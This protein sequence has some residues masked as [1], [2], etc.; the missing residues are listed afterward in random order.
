MYLIKLGVEVSFQVDSVEEVIDKI[1]T[2]QFSRPR[3]DRVITVEHRTDMNNPVFIWFNSGGRLKHLYGSEY[4]LYV[5]SATGF[6]LQVSLDKH[7]GHGG[8]DYKKFIT[9]IEVRCSLKRLLFQEGK[10]ST[11]NYQAVTGENQVY[12]AEDP[13]T[14]ANYAAAYMKAAV[15]ENSALRISRTDEGHSVLYPARVDLL[16]RNSVNA[17]TLASGYPDRTLFKRKSRPSGRLSL[18]AAGNS[19]RDLKESVMNALIESK[20]FLPIS[21]SMS[22]WDDNK[23]VEIQ[24][25]MPSFTSSQPLHYRES[26]NQSEDPS[27]ASDVEKAKRFLKH[28]SGSFNGNPYF[29]EDGYPKMEIRL[30]AAAAL[31]VLENL[32]KK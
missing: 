3:Y 8:D 7:Q 32:E 11:S 12:V 23:D 29:F 16:L 31:K 30:E 27:T 2:L 26:V 13:V 19:C 28:L 21:A 24:G 17:M 10:P 5:D 9:E 18:S 25:D 1:F 20:E 15:C 14:I 6:I 4:A 22:M